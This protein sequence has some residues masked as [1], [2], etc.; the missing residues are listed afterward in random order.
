MAKRQYKKPVPKSQEE[1]SKGLQEPYDKS[2][3]N[4]NPEVNSPLSQTNTGFNRG[5]KL[6]HTGDTTKQFTVGIQDID[7]SILYYF[8]NIIRPSII[9]NGERIAV[10]VRYGNQEAW[11]SFQKDGYLRDNNGALLNPLIM[12]KRNSIDSEKNIGNKLDANQPHLYTS[13]GK[14]YNVKNSYSNFNILNNRIPTKQFIANVI[15]NYVTVTYECIIQTYYVEQLNKVIES[16]NYASNSYWGDPSRFKFRAMIDSFSSVVEVR[17][18]GNRVAK[19]NFT[20]KLNGYIIPDIIQKDLNSVKKY[21]EK[22]KITINLETDSPR[23][24]FD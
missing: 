13:W 20:I 10:P 11:K 4:P 12:F 3:G 15:P 17:A 21:N 7:E 14:Q 1:I 16:I 24:I 6:S 5:E 23:E 8:D 2:V 22:S 9:Q 19:S 18:D